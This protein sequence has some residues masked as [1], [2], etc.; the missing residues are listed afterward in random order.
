MKEDKFSRVQ[1]MANESSDLLFW[2]IWFEWPKIG[3]SDDGMSSIS[4]L[5]CSESLRCSLATS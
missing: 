2:P 5:L 1:P 3:L 4:K